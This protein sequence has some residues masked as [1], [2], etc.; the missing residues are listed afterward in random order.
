[1]VLKLIQMF[2]WLVLIPLLIGLF[3]EQCW[4]IAG[5]YKRKNVQNLQEPEVKCESAFCDAGKHLIVG[6]ILMWALFQIVTVPA[7]FKGLRLPQVSFV[8]RGICTVLGILSIFILCGKAVREQLKTEFVRVM[9]T[10]RSGFTKDIRTVFMVVSWGIFLLLLLFQCYQS[11]ALAYADG[12][13]SFYISISTAANL[14]GSMYLLDPYTGVPT[15]FDARHGLAPFPIWVSFVAE[16]MGVNTAVA[17]HTWI[18][19]V[20]IPLTYVIYGLIGKALLK[21]H[22]RYVPVFLNFIALLQIFGNYSI[23][24]ASTFLL[25]RMRQGKTALGNIILPFALYLLLQIAEE[26]KENKRASVNSMWMLFATSFAAC[27]CSTMS[28]FLLMLL[29][30]VAVGLFCI[31]YKS[32]KIVVQYV[33]GCSPCVL[34]AFLYFMVSQ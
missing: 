31:Y 20:L 28:G 11:Y 6:Y 17:A 33:L 32:W 15:T 7:I 3:A 14:G 2:V 25:T 22:P 18:P 1:M 29:V 12:D 23:Y 13:D 9:Q 34:Y 24:P 26:V 27:L 21:E 30:G 19:L 10:I 16:Q 5:L 8:F 4:F